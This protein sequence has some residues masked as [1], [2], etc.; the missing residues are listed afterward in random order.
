M[1]WPWELRNP[2]GYSVMLGRA[3]Y[4]HALRL[5]HEEHAIMFAPPRSGKSGLLA[6][7]MLQYPGPV[8]STTTRADIFTNTQQARRG[9]GRVDVFNPQGI[10][11]VPSTMAWDPISGC[12][13]IAT[14]IRRADAFAL[15]V[16]TQGVEDGA[17]WA[18]KT[19]D[20]L[21]AFF[22]AA[23]FAQSKGVRYGLPTTAR[24]ALGGASQ[25]AEEIL[26]DAGALDWAAQLQELRG[27][28]QKTAATV[29]M[30]MTRA[31]GFLF[32]P[33]LARS[34]TP[35]DDDPGLD[36][37]SFAEHQD[38]LYLIASGQGEQSPLAPLF[39]AL[40]NEIH[41]T[42]GLAGSYSRNGRLPHPMLF[43]L[44][45]ITQVCPVPLPEWLADSGGK[46]IQIIPVVHGEAQLRKR[47]GKDGARVVMDTAGTWV[48]LPGVSDPDTL[49]M[50]SGLCGEVAIREHG[51]D[52]HAR[53]P[54]LTGDMI[55]QLPAKRA[56]VKRT[57][58]SPVVVRVRQVWENPV[59]KRA[60]KDP[61][62][63]VAPRPPRAIVPGRVVG[64]QPGSGSE[65]A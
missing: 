64:S 58:L 8:L 32:D 16:T 44:D 40:A 48:V 34:V 14:A 21:R 1:I 53:H 59:H 22:Y 38:T 43:A 18:A 11:R 52:S 37:E 12:L 7:I 39:A 47:W 65:A 55:R 62:P 45:E 5:P 19:S 46:G 3:H 13:D 33:A 27:E 63:S 28:A 6:D 29:R 24:W 15:A 61:L 60:R 35:R 4:G 30:Y 57:N 54:V 51:H 25:E 50:L 2:R 10:G 41:Y 26:T 20:Y 36:P 56:L 42:A 49:R 9:V 31:L 17:F 23:A